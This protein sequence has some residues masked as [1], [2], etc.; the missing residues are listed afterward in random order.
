MS[1]AGN[2]AEEA[3]VCCEKG[4]FFNVLLL[5]LPAF[6]SVLSQG[7]P[8]GLGS[9]WSVPTRREDPSFGG[10]SIDKRPPRC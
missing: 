2:A 6:I 5:V 3:P 8:L 4:P 9:A 7:P 1:C 10:R